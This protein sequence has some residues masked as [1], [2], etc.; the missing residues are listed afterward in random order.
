MSL[1]GIIALITAISACTGTVLNLVLLRDHTRKDLERFQ[2]HGR[3][4]DQLENG[5]PKPPSEPTSPP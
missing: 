2:W 1:G 5:G 4:L 3:R